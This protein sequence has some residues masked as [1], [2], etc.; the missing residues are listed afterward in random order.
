MKTRLRITALTLTLLLATSLV[1]AQFVAAPSA[2]TA[3]N[4]GSSQ[5]TKID[6]CREINESGHYEL[7][8][9]LTDPAGTECLSVNADNVTLDGNGHTVRDP[10][11]SSI[12]GIGAVGDN[13]T[14]RNVRV[15]GWDTAIGAGDNVTVRNVTVPA[16]THMNENAV[17][18][19]ADAV[20]TDSE[21]GEVSVIHTIEGTPRIAG[22]IVTE[23]VD[24]RRAS[25]TVVN[26]TV[27]GDVY[28]HRSGD[29]LVQDNDITGDVSA[30]ESANV[31]VTG[32]RID[33]T[34]KRSGVLVKHTLGDTTV[35]HNLVRNATVGVRLVAL[36]DDEHVIKDNRIENNTYGIH[37]SKLPSGEQ[38]DDCQLVVVATNVTIR[39]N[40]IADNEEY[41]VYNEGSIV[42]DATQNYWGAGNG[43]ASPDS[44]PLA[45][46]LAGVPADGSG[47]AV[48]AWA[49]HPEKSNVHFDGQL[50]VEPATIPDEEN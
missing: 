25:A 20:L 10:N 15:V 33:A 31:T 13:V 18:L 23:G 24:V 47:D 32:N 27:H 35:T 2:A 4:D 44:E 19:D 16:G 6:S 34:R 46:P 42:L 41:G 43:P 48:S 3:G 21:V 40:V 45:D 8:G 22:N 7:T 29:T 36:S 17:N 50:Q 30:T 37:A 12:Q 11:G 28:V 39:G 9:N 26:N 14:V 1:G 38:S 49:D 5:A